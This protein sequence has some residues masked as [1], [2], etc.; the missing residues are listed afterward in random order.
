M[1]EDEW[2]AELV[3]ANNNFH[4]EDSSAEA[5]EGFSQTRGSGRDCGCAIERKCW[6]DCSKIVSRIARAVKNK[7][8]HFS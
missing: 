7:H 5:I 3:F 6:F 1:A 2:V 8:K 4:T